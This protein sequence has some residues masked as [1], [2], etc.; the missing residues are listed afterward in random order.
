MGLLEY[1][2]SRVVRLD[3]LRRLRS[4]QWLSTSTQPPIL[5]GKFLFLLVSP[6]CL[7]PTPWLPILD[8]P[9]TFLQFRNEKLTSGASGDLQDALPPHRHWGKEG[10]YKAGP[11][12][13]RGELQWYSDPFPVLEKG[14]VVLNTC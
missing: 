1:S 14:T 6:W 5:N 12:G 4:Q 2:L 8:L 13:R 9:P 11:L 10:L 3:F 7:C